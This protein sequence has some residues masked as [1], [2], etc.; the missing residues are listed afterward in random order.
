MLRIDRLEGERRRNDRAALLRSRAVANSCV[1]KPGGKLADELLTSTQLMPPG[2]CTVTL[3]DATSVDRQRRRR[4][5]RGR[6]PLAVTPVTRP[7][8]LTVATTRRST[9]R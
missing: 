4:G 6:V 1:W 2:C 9:T 8:A 7:V 3:T 5:D